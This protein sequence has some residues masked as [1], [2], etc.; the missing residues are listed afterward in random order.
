ME[1]YAALTIY[2]VPPVKKTVCYMKL[3][4]QTL[5]RVQT[6]S[7]VSKNYIFFQDI[8]YVILSRCLSQLKPALNGIHKNEF[9]NQ[10]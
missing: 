2:E 8:Y 10:L 4:N 5:R 7:F 6:Q 3:S 9:I 1:S